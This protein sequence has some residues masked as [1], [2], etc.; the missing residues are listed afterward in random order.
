MIDH[1]EKKREKSACPRI[2]SMR[3]LLARGAMLPVAE[4][5]EI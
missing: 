3:G 1:S 2:A 5:Y 4:N